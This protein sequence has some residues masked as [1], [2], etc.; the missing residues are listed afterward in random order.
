LGGVIQA[1][2]GSVFCIL[3]SEKVQDGELTDISETP[4]YIAE[5]LIIK[6]TEKIN[7]L[8]TKSLAKKDD[9]TSTI[10]INLP[11]S[12]K[13]NDEIKNVTSYKLLTNTSGG[14]ILQVLQ[15]LNA[16]PAAMLTDSL[17]TDDG[18][19]IVGLSSQVTVSGL[20]GTQAY[21]ILLTAIQVQGAITLYLRD[22]KEKILAC[23][24][25]DELNAISIGFD[26]F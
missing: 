1:V 22:V 21:L 11:A 16:L 14:N 25:I 19:T 24:T 23:S 9:L 10:T 7:E 26:E 8:L 2:D 13:K 3:A 6:K 15:L 4:E 20:T 5:Q 18:Y 17:V 12:L